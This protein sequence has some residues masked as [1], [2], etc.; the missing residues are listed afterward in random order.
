LLANKIYT[1]QWKIENSCGAITDNM[2]INTN[3]TNGPKQANAGTDQC[4]GASST[5]FNLAANAPDAGETGIWTL[6]P[7]SP[8]TP[9]FTNASSQTVTGATMGTYKFEWQL[10]KGGCST[11]RDTVVITIS[12]GTT[13]AAINGST[14]TSAQDICGLG[15]VTLTATNAALASGEVGTWTQTA[16]AGGAVITSP[17][18]SST[19]ITGLGEGRYAFRYTITNSACSSSFAEVNLNLNAPPTPAI[20]SVSNTNPITL[21]DAT[22]TVLDANT[23]TVG[24]GLWLVQSGPNAPTFSSLSDP[25]ATISGLQ[26]GTYVLMWQSTNGTICPPSTSTVTIIVHQSANAGADQA[27]CNTSTTILSGNEGSDGIWT[28][29]SSSPAGAPPVTITKN[30]SSTGFGNTAIITGLVPN[31]NYVFRYTI[32]T[33]LTGTKDAG[34]CGT[35][36]DDMTVAVSGPPSIADAGTDQQI[37]TSNTTQVTLAAATPTVG[38]GSWDIIS[39][40]NGSLLTLSSTTD[41]QAILSNLSVQGDYLLQ[42]TVTNANCTGTQS[43]NDIVRISVYNPPTTA[44]PMTDQ[45]AACLGNITLTG[46]TPTVGIGTWTFVPNGPGDTRAPV[47]DAPNVP[48]TT[49]SGLVV[50]PANPYKFR[51]TI[52]NGTCTASSADVNITVKDKT[53][54]TANAGAV[55]NTCATTAGGTA[56]VNLAS[57][58]TTL[59]GNDQGTWTIVTQPPLALQ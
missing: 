42:W 57:T 39:R 55:A 38:T 6:L 5:I 24:S 48:T 14:G 40:P 22:S 4:L 26:L 45:P 27:L 2:V 43:S 10:T 3:G 7:G 11:T 54:A 46:N 33:G 44:S 58:N 19:T 53:P 31:T 8:N 28:L 23:I 20:A 59:T 35:L 41:P 32:N 52:T 15:P 13:V 21:C 16:G 30:G 1:L 49:V 9:A 25:H 18:A 37:C 34:G 47:I 51:W 17:N 12:P 50:D 36:T 29:V 56:S